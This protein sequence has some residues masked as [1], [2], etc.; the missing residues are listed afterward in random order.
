MARMVHL[1]I[2][3]VLGCRR[4]GRHQPHFILL[5]ITVHQFIRGSSVLATEYGGYWYGYDPDL[6]LVEV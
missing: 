2:Y 5:Q 1:L 3:V 4:V 6:C